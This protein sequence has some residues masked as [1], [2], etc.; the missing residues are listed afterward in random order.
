MQLRKW[1]SNLDEALRDLEPNQRGKSVELTNISSQLEEYPVIKTLG[2]IWQTEDDL[3]R[4][5]QGSIT[6]EGGPW[7]Q[8]RLLSTM[9]KLFD[10]LGLLAPYII[11]ARAILQDLVIGQYQIVDPWDRPL[12]ESL[13][14]E[15]KV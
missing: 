9:A 2:L 13:E 7:T 14:K 5:E 15:W 11:L 12:P 3:F 8:R 10:P 4:F 6:D 1:A